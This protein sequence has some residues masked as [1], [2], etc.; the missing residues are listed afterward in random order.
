MWVGGNT[1]KKTQFLGKKWTS[2]ISS[3]RFIITFT[4]LSHKYTLNHHQHRH[5]ILYGSAIFCVFF[6]FSLSF[7]LI[8]SS[9]YMS[10]LCFHCFFYIFATLKGKARSLYLRLLTFENVAKKLYT[11][12]PIWWCHL[13]TFTLHSAHLNR[14]PCIKLDLSIRNRA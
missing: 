12:T 5:Y 8:H 4:Y 10:I 1:K 11:L 7:I 3:V 13:C 9:I 14:F 6:Q 2:T